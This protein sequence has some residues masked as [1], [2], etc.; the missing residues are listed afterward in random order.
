MFVP[1][2]A[3]VFREARRVLSD[4]GLLA[5]NV[6]DSL[7]HNPFAHVAHETIGGFFPA[8]PPRFYEVPYGFSD[9]EPWLE[10]LSAHGFAD[11]EL[12]TV[13]LQARSPTA[14]HL[15]LGLV[16]GTPVSN[17]IAQRDGDFD[18]IV[19]AVTAAL[20][21]LGG[22]APFRSTMRAL[23]FTARAH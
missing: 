17:M 10:L 12:E 16:Q 5:F 1:E 7:E 13:T 23:V 11:H 3:A 20:A 18:K 9:P 6:W 2:K 8:D 15:A 4:G 22:E 19:A 21:R 14:Q